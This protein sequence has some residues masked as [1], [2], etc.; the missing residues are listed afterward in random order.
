MPI[1]NIEEIE[2]S[3]LTLLG[4]SL[5]L[6]RRNADSA[7]SNP[8]FMTLPLTPQHLNFQFPIYFNFQ[9]FCRVVGIGRKK[10]RKGFQHSPSS[11]RYGFANQ[12][13]LLVP[14]DAL[15]CQPMGGGGEFLP[16][17]AG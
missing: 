15:S 4:V 11:N 1:I 10:C 16:G 13:Q 5:V 6:W 8:C 17:G 9:N 2:T 3:L 14:F 7:L 12:L